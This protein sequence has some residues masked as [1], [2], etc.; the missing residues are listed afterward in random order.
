[1]GA[2]EDFAAIERD[3]RDAAGAFAAIEG[4]ASADAARDFAAIEITAPTAAPERT[5]RDFTPAGPALHAAKALEPV[6]AALP[7]PSDEERAASATRRSRSELARA[8]AQ[9]HAG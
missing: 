9:W 5:W 7:P 4:A 3:E 1:M 6:A 8:F 2:L